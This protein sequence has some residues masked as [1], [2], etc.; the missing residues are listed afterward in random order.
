MEKQYEVD[1]EVEIDLKE[2]LFELL[3]H[4]VVIL[5]TTV[6]VAGI[7]FCVSK[8][9]MV[10]QYESTA[11]LYVFSKSTSITSLA[12]IQIGSNLTND[13]SVVAKGRPVLEQVINN[14]GLEESYQGLYNKVALNN[15]SNSRILQ[16][17]VTDEDPNQAKLIADEIATVVARYIAEKMNQE[18]PTIISY[19]YADGGA[20]SPNTLKNTM[21]G[22]IAGGFLAVAVVVICYLLNDTIMSTE[23]IENKLKLN[24]LGTLPLEEDAEDRT[25]TSK[26]SSNKKNTKGGRKPQISA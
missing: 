14:L 15:P 25:A 5:L 1:D 7:A 23:D 6:L 26:H 11:E 8:F 9:I 3:N 22:A 18:A 17:T 19:G 10:P 21:I 4:W 2:L 20:V 12:D 24:V 13:Y 16:I